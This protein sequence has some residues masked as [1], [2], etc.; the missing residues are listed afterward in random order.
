MKQIKLMEAL[1]ILRAEPPGPARAFRAYL[2]CGFSPLHLETF[3]GAYFRLALP[4]RKT[5]V[6]SGLYGDI[7]GNLDKLELSD[8]DVGLVIM[9]WSDLDPRLGLR[10]LG[11]WEPSILPE[12]L[13]EARAKTSL[14][15]VKLEK[16]ARRKSLVVSLPTLPL[17]PISFSPGWQASSFDLELRALTSSTAVRLGSMVNVKLVNVERLDQLSP[18][19]GRLD[20]RSEISSGFPY[21][22]THASIVAE[23]M[24]RMAVPTMPKKGLITDLDDTLWSGIL[25]E[26]G[27]QGVFW[28]LEH[29]SQIHGL[30]QR[31]LGALSESG[32]LIAGASKNDL[33]VVQEAFERTDLVL[34]GT[35][36]FPVEA[37]WNPKSTSVDRILR[38][39]NISAD[40]VVFVD[41][42]PMELAEVK[43]AHPEIECIL[44][45]K[46]NPQQLLELLWKLRDYFG[47][48]TLSEED[49]LR[50]ESIRKSRENASEFESSNQ[51]LSRFLEQAVAEL[52]LNT[53]KELL[54]RRAFELVNKT[55][56]FNL[57][58][59]RY[60][61][62]EWQSY[63]E[64][65]ETFLLVAAYRDK[66]GPLGKIAVL[67]GKRQEKTL[68]LDT[69]VMSCRAFSR[70]IEHRCIEE[71]FTRF[72]VDAIEFD[73]Q[74]TKK[75]GP[76]Q[77]FLRSVLSG[78]PRPGCQLG[79]D[80][81]LS[82]RQ[83]TFHRVLETSNG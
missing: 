50:R 77:E 47:K 66:Y 52:S 46:D 70:R 36:I 65:P 15:V 1:E 2:A 69:W 25:G 73:F 60:T 30:Y 18:L 9:E 62:A 49:A 53:S 41:D 63:I 27:S 11:S 5:E 24:S 28:D 7:S 68:F 51:N 67:A 33:R 40:A 61:E 26:V 13:G 23:L 79:K 19:S 14:L 17:P 83:E 21:K 54:D 80:D 64:R 16:I 78:E 8:A 48:D 3:F 29:H 4:D 38:T 81:F 42:S 74:L 71:L 76:L 58:G 37:H 59:R 55:N 12:I 10:S 75:N 72:P 6:L 56:Q 45:P 39:W 82:V 22:V 35:A 57:N 43:S 44:F 34:P 31:L 20:S 32:V